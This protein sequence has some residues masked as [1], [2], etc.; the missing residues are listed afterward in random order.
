MNRFGSPGSGCDCSGNRE[1]PRNRWHHWN[2]RNLLLFF[3]FLAII[4]DASAATRYDPRLRFRTLSTARFDI[5]YHQGEEALAQRLARIAEQVAT[6]VGRTLGPAAGRVQV[7]LVDQNDLPNGWATPVPYNTIEIAAAAPRASSLIGNVDDWLRLVFTHEYV[8]VVHLS[9]AQGWIGGLRHVFGRMPLLYPNLFQPIW[10]I[11]GIATWQESAQTG[12]GR[13]PAADFRLLLEGAAAERRLEPLDRASSRIADWPSGNTPYLYGAYFHQYLAETYGADSLA[14]LTDATAGRLPYLGA[15]AFRQVFGRSLGELWR[16]FESSVRAAS[17]APRAAERLTTHGFYVSGPSFMDDGRLLYSLADPH[18]VPALMELQPGGPAPRRVAPRYLG[19]QI[20]VHGGRAVVD[21]IEIVHDVGY[22]SDL[23]EVDVATGDERRLSTGA[24][25]ADPDLSPDGQRLAFVIQRA[26]RRELA[27]AP[28]TPGVALA[29]VTLVSAPEVHFAAPR[30]SPDGS[31]IAAERRIRGGDAE[32]VV[33]NVATGTVASVVPSGRNSAPVWLRD[34]SAILFSASQGGGPFQIYSVAAGGGELR[35]LEGTG[36]SAQS[37]AVSPDGRTLVFVG[38]TGDGYDLFSIPLAGAR[39]T[40]T[41]ENVLT[42]PPRAPAQDGGAPEVDSREY[43]PLRTVLPRFWTPTVERD[44]DE[45]VVGAATGSVDALARHAYGVEAGW[46]AGRG[47]PDWQ[48]A[49][50]YDRWRPT[51][52]IVASDDTDPWRGGEH[53]VVEGSVGVVTRARRVRWSRSLLGEVHRSDE[54]LDCPGAAE[55]CQ[56]DVGRARRTA[57][58]G[59]ISF[60][61]ARMFGYSISPEEGGRLA[62]TIEAARARGADSPASVSTVIDARY[63]QRAW[64]RHAA[65]AL[66]AAAASSWGDA[67]ARRV[68]SASGSDAQGGGF[69]FGSDA[70]GLI[71]GL[72]ADRVFGPHAAV[73]NLDYRVPLAHIERG[74]GTAPVLLRAI[75]AAAF[76]DAGHA[77]SDRFARADIRYATGAELSIDAIVGYFLPVTFTAGG[78]WRGGPDAADRGFAAFARIGRAF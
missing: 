8:H 40:A 62:A 9:R 34:G 41:A 10:L 14:R 31:S 76:V 30:W 68:F 29:P 67:A 21:R 32:I 46:T 43:S 58:R 6:D 17:A 38:Y 50:A 27:T 74:L 73:V 47:R 28:F 61:A 33:V 52:F 35:R 16:D 19:E 39:W 4:G 42:A 65:V 20:G 69:R 60:D 23:Y 72:D 12:A 22:Q 3:V 36:P 66:R 48:A 54:T 5:H 70:I 15:G 18:R 57:L 51:F 55:A 63:Y 64:P 1:H 13:V 11:E 24:R 2:P 71:R 49:Y 25:A 78:A 44:E 7:I 53:R 59:G 26:D 75:H 45:W 37:P 56:A 77:W